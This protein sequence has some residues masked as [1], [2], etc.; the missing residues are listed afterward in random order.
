MIKDVKRRKTVKEFGAERMRINSLRKN[1][2]LPVELRV[3]AFC[4]WGIMRFLV[5]TVTSMKITAFQD[6]APCSLIEVD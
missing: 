4:R 2:I 5:L 1:D 6:I 3:N